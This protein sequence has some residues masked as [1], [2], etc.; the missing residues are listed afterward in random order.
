MNPKF[1]LLL[2]S[3]SAFAV[4]GSMLLPTA[5]SG[6]AAQVEDVQ[7]L[8]RGPVHEAFAESVSFDPVAGVIIS[9]LVPEAIE[10]LPP[11]Q[12]LEGD[13]VTWIPGY[14]AWDDDQSDF[15][16]IS[17]IWRNLPPGRQWVPGYW[18]EIDGGQSQ[19]TSGY[20]AD[21]TVT[22]VS[23]VATA[24]PRSI[25]SGPN[26]EA[27]SAD[28]S[29]VPGNW[30]W[31]DTRYAWRPGYWVPQRTNWTWVPSRYNWTRRGYV[32]VDGYW[33]YAVARR[34][35]LFAPVYFNRHVYRQPNYYYTPSIVVALSVFSS[36]LFV[37]PSS[38]HYYFG[39]YY[40]PRYRDS[41]Y[42]A[43]FSWHSGRRGYDP[44]YAYDRWSHRDDRGWERRRSE[45]Y[46]YFRDHENARPPRTWAAMRDYR[47][48]RF[49]D[50]RNRSYATALSTYAQDTKS[51]QR[52]RALDDGRRKQ[53]A[54]QR[55][56][57]N[58]FGQER[59]QLESRG[60]AAGDRSKVG[61]SREKL[62]RSPITGRETAK[63]AKNE[64]PPKRPEA[65]ADKSKMVAP[66]KNKAKD[67]VARKDGP[68]NPRSAERGV[69]PRD[70]EARAGGKAAAPGKG[71]DSPANPRSAE[72][73]VTPRDD[74]ARAGGKAAAPGQNRDA[75]T[76]NAGKADRPKG[77]A[78]KD[79]NKGK[80]QDREAKPKTEL[81]PAPG[82]KSQAAPKR[83]I[84]PKPQGRE[85]QP[86]AAD[87]PTTERKPQVSQKRE[88]QP[89]RRGAGFFG[90]DDFLRRALGDDFAAAVAGFGA[91]VEDPV[92]LGGDGHVVLDDD[93][94]VA[95]IDEAVEDVDEAADV[96]V[97]EA[98]GGLF[99]E[100][101][102]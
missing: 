3:V 68:A 17:G 44:I 88:A 13:N 71:K 7:I 67:G 70:D 56:E 69:T 8:T 33:D 66:A 80:G 12:Q 99:D 23:Y 31:V 55:Q 91:E 6:Q 64:A 85:I 86:K 34:G 93:D 51:G 25:D 11:E 19:W 9:A 1:H 65:R 62:A 37:R 24:P 57:I 72:R 35:V 58:K 40:S 38:G 63:F 98:D 10:E 101:E 46:N 53:I 29:W 74:E 54:S 18:S 49:N 77:A 84:Q 5:A 50:G 79:T 41:G 83:E 47:E 20:W 102:I 30:F 78:E 2:G 32:H 90:D 96:L 27:P 95:F 15:I 42:Y 73:G 45:D 60:I 48:D 81:R 59:R 92:G 28:H 82:T 76:G 16:W 61:A 22:E 14:W 26:I 52:F 100:I 75:K 39:D 21:A 97:V 94:G 4:A 36:H 43:S 89:K 87:R